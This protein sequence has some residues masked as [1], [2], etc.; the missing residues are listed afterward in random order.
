[1][2]KHTGRKGRVTK[3]QFAKEDKE[4]YYGEW[5]VVSSQKWGKKGRV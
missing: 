5:K 2:G 4:L 3:A 1:L